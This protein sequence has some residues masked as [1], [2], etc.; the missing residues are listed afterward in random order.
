MSRAASTSGTWKAMWPQPGRLRGAA[1]D[2]L[3]VLVDLDGRAGIAVARQA[4]VGAGQVGVVELRR[5]IEVG[6]PVV[7]L[8]RHQGAAEDIAVEGGQDPPVG[9][10]DVDVPEPGTLDRGHIASFMRYGPSLAASSA[11]RRR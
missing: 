1:L 4:E 3:V 7:A 2:H 10:G 9:P 11:N 8:R 6:A 5:P